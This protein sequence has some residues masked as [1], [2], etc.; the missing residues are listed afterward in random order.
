MVSGSLTLS[1]YILY[2]ALLCRSAR[3]MAG[4]LTVIFR[5]IA[6]ASLP[7]RP[8]RT[9]SLRLRFTSLPF[10]LPVNFPLMHLFEIDTVEIAR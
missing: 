2:M 3:C 1:K 6:G 9:L 7:K 4:N 10:S 5:R 8:R